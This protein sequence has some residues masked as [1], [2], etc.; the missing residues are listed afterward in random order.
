M[1]LTDITQDWLKD[2]LKAGD[3][4]IDATLGNGFDALFLAQQIGESGRLYGFDVQQQAITQS[5]KLLIDEPCQ[6][7][8]FLKGHEHIASVLPPETKGQ[9]K[10]VMFNLGWL[11]GSDKNIITKAETT[12]SALEQS[13]IWLAPGGKMS[14]MV[15]PGHQGGDSEAADVIHWLEQR[16]ITAENGLKLEKVIVPDR[17]TAPLLLK[18]AKL[19]S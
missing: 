19:L 2:I 7:S 1:R 14:V 3:S 4:A 6:K 16:C 8:F 11:P 9:I 18:V 12:I 13:I 5:E 15:Y 10:V 17:P